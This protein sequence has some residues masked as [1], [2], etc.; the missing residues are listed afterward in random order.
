MYRMLLALAVVAV[1][2]GGAVAGEISQA[3]LND[4]GLASMQKMSDDEGMAV[5]G[6]WAFV[7]G[8]G[9]AAVVGG[10]SST[11]GYMAGTDLANPTAAA[12]ANLSGAATVGVV[13]GVFPFGAWW[14]AGAGQ[15]SLAA[16]GS[17][18]GAW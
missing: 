15:I 17:M 10:T 6:K 9:T 12:G 1:M 7:W 14:V 5:R 8:Q 18:A 13:G 2:A 4:M 3:T 11:N 16:G